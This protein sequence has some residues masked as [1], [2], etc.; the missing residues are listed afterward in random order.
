MYVLIVMIIVIMMM[1]LMIIIRDKWGQRQGVLL[2]LWCL[3]R[4]NVVV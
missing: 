3:S 2:S 1:I 4:I